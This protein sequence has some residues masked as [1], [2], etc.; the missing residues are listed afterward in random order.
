MF[1]QGIAVGL[2]SFD[3]ERKP[4]EAEGGGADARG[5]KARDQGVADMCGQT[6][7]PRGSAV[8]A[9]ILE[10]GNV[11]PC[12]LVGAVDVADRRRVRREHDPVAQPHRAQRRQAL[13]AALA[14]RGDGE[15]LPL[16]VFGAIHL[17]PDV[18]DSLHALSAYRPVHLYFPDPCRQYWADFKTQR[19]LLQRQPDS[20]DLYYEIGHPLLVSLGRM[21]QDFFIRI[22]L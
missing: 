3:E 18:L 10:V 22:I 7:D 9:A 19:E 16:H 5:L 8:A 17:A 12:F 20:D 1:V 21:A 4:E 11:A 2:H 6:A 14:A 15:S 13:L